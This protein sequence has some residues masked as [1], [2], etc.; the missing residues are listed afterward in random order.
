MAKKKS[1]EAKLA[2]AVAEM[3]IEKAQS[4]FDFLKALNAPKKER[5]PRA[6]TVGATQ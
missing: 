6:K 2:E 1:P 5:K 4:F 3:G